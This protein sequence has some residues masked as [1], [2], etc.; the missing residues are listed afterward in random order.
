[1]RSLLAVAFAAPALAAAGVAAALPAQREVL[2]LISFGLAVIGLVAYLFTF[3][4]ERLV[5]VRY[6][7]RRVPPLAARV[8]LPACLTLAVVGIALALTQHGSHRTLETLGVAAAFAGAL[9]AALFFLLSLFSIHTAVSMLG[10][11]LGVSCLVVIS[12]VTSGFEREFQKS[13]FAVNGHLIVMSYGNPTFEESGREAKE[14]AAKV[15]D[16]PGLERVERFS[17]SA[18]EVMVGKVGANLKGV[19]LSTG[20]PELK[21]ALVAGSV[22]ALG[23]PAS[24]PTA[25]PGGRTG[26][27]LLGA[28]LARKLRAKVGDCVSVLVPFSFS[29]D[30]GALPSFAFQVAGLFHFGFNEYDARLAYVSLPDAEW[31]S[32][33]RGTVIGV[34]LRFA[35][36]M[37]ALSLVDTVAERLGPEMRVIDWKTLNGNIFTALKLQKVVLSLILGIIIVVAAFN[38]VASLTLI[39]LTKTREIAILG[40]MGARR[41]SVLRVFLVAGGLVGVI[42]AGIGLALG[43]LACGLLARYGYVLDS[44]V[45][46]VEKLPVLISPDE[47][48]VIAAIAMAI[49]LVFTIFP[50]FKASR[51]RALDGL[52]YT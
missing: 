48:L 45:Y 11:A 44:K 43:F 10:V 26:R 47:I 3:A 4:F 32:S 21:P 7:R 51:L 2:L 14:I 18:G 24:C 34:E 9:F 28:E 42:G 39:V 12:S 40:S 27:I 1:M 49:C 46:N 38:T 36:P 35:D 22:E 33:A 15:K 17:L 8:G 29:D 23:K 16:L 13:V 25:D 37:R 52:R 50:A 31:V 19:D 41:G 6:L 20:A 5:A 30:E